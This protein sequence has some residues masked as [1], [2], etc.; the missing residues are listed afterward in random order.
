MSLLTS[1]ALVTSFNPQPNVLRTPLSPHFLVLQTPFS[2]QPLLLRAAFSHQPL[3]LQ[4]A[5]SSQ[6]LVRV[7]RGLGVVVGRGVS[8]MEDEGHLDDHTSGILATDGAWHHIAVTWQSSD[9]RTAL[10]DNGRKVV[11]APSP[12]VLSRRQLSP[13]V[14]LWSRPVSFACTA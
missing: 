5:V 4:T 10:Y 11:A 6:P 1:K 3:V 14:P 8:V 9:G 7:G 2:P 12:H 13:I